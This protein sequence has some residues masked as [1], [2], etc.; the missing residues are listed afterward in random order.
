VWNVVEVLDCYF[1]ILLWKK[2]SVLLYLML[3]SQ[4]VE[5]N[6]QDRVFCLHRVLR[7]KY[8]FS[9]MKLFIGIGV[10]GKQLVITSAYHQ[11][12]S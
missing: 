12:Q 11:S 10:W 3:K 8:I 6:N 9:K 5:H 2:S 7:K 1:D 4:L